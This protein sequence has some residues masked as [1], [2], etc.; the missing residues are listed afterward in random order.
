MTTSSRDI[1]ILPVARASLP[2]IEYVSVFVHV[3]VPGRSW[4]AVHPFLSFPP[5]S[6]AETVV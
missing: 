3:R 1:C 5:I 6:H 4:F 2:I